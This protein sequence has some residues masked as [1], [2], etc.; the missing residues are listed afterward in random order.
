MTTWLF[1]NY[2]QQ[3]N[4]FRFTDESVYNRSY[5]LVPFSRMWPVEKDLILCLYLHKQHS[6]CYLWSSI[7]CLSFRA[8][9]STLSFVLWG[10]CCFF[11]LC[12]VFYCLSVG[13]FVGNGHGSFF[14]NEIEW[15]SFTTI[16][17]WLTTLFYYSINYRSTFMDNLILWQ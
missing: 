9:V 6:W 14:T 4:C 17:P 1:I 5:N 11:L 13:L 3:H 12:C 16:V 15:R 7:L 2:H 10:T 8:P